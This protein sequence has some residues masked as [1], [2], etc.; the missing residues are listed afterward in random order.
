MYISRGASQSERQRYLTGVLKSQYVLKRLKGRARIYIIVSQLLV[1]NH[2]Q[3]CTRVERVDNA[4][5]HIIVSFALSV[6][7]L[8]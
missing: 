5:L 4:E 8:F 3:S 7:G 6:F 1:S 2:S